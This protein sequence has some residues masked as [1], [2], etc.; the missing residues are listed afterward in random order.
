MQQLGSMALQMIGNIHFYIERKGIKKRFGLFVLDPFFRPTRKNAIELYDT[1]LCARSFQQVFQ[2]KQP[3]FHS[4]LLDGFNQFFDFVAH[5]Q[6]KIGFD[7]K[8]F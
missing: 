5:I 2:K 4:Y 6:G 3:L 8:E 1:L 7:E